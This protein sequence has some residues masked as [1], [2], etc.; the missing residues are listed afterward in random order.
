MV[1]IQGKIMAMAEKNT[2][3]GLKLLTIMLADD[4]G[5]VQLNFFNQDYLKKKL[6][7]QKSSLFVHGK[8]GY[9]YGGYGQLA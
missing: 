4:T 9:A 7:V 1:N 5:V 3:R 6:K 8:V 2:R